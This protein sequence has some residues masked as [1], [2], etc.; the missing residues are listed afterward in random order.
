MRQCDDADRERDRSLARVCIDKEALTAESR[1]IYQDT[2]RDVLV[3]QFSMN[4]FSSFPLARFTGNIFTLV[5][6]V[7]RLRI[8]F[9]LNRLYQI[10]NCVLPAWSCASSGARKARLDPNH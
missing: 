8:S 10:P 9:P 6:L 7:P 5:P 3:L 4:L 2:Y 1:V